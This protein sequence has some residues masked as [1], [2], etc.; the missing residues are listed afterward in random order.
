MKTKGR[1]KVNTRKTKVEQQ[2]K[3]WKSANTANEKM[4][5]IAKELGWD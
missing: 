1:F 2:I 4:S 3:D 5:L